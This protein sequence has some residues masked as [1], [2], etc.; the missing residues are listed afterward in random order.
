DPETRANSSRAYWSDPN[1]L[2]Q[3]RDRLPAHIYRRL[4]LKLPGL[5]EG[6][7]YTVEKVMDAIDRGVTSRPVDRDFSVVAGFVD[8]S[9]G[10]NDDAVLAI[11]ALDG[12]NRAV[13]LRILNQ[14]PPAPFDPRAAVA[15]FATVLKEHGCH[16][17]WGDKYGGETYI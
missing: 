6:S 2:A 5:P 17:V 10:S 1:Y 12:N 13:L 16:R 4:H 9:G 8:M 7:A 15:R 3:Q 11:A 14:G